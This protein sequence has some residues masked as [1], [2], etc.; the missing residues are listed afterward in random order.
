MTWLHIKEAAAALNITRRSVD[1][2]IQ[3]GELAEK[4]GGEGRFV[5]VAP[6]LEDLH[7]Q[8][9][10]RWTDIL[11]EQSQVIAGLSKEVAELRQVIEKNPRTPVSHSDINVP[12]PASKCARIYP[13][14]CAD[15][16]QA[17]DISPLSARAIERQAGLAT[18]FLAKAR[19]GEK[20]SARSDGSWSKLRA[21]FA[22]E[23]AAA[24]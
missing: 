1:R 4:V 23:F 18:G 20:R 10:E 21:F 9:R 12:K 7:R 14:P 22:E 17:V 13:G 19:K 11:K 6:R 3:S 8:E 2:K 24:G 15:L 5:W 16:L